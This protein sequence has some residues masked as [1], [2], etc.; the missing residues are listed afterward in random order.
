M[1]KGSYVA[2]ITPMRADGSVDEAET[3]DPSRIVTDPPTGV[4]A[5]GRA[6]ETTDDAATD[7]PARDMTGQPGSGDLADLAALDEQ[8]ESPARDPQLG[9]Y[10]ELIA[11]D[12]EPA[13]VGA[14]V[15]AQDITEAHAAGGFADGDHVVDETA[16][17]DS[18]TADHDE[19]SAEP[20]S[21][22]GEEHDV[23]LD[24]VVGGNDAGFDGDSG[25]EAEPPA[26]A[27]QVTPD[28]DGER[29]TVLQQ[30]G[31]EP[32][33]DEAT[34]D[35]ATGEPGPPTVLGR[36]RRLIGSYPAPVGQP[37]ATGPGRLRR[38]TPE[39]DDAS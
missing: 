25:V 16:I 32:A 33:E 20:G 28:A 10:D 30:A 23:G 2:L 24:I 8:A 9:G 26:E 6:G 7:V 17:A 37:P 15:A 1:F 5:D 11:A 31:E 27:A 18:E 3:P 14:P 19:R 29:S 38:A 4:S 39:S 21:H 36:L 35:E 13:D 12:D 34:E 22:A